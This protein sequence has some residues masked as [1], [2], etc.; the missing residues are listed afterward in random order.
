MQHS[1]WSA[2]GHPVST[3]NIDTN[4]DIYRN[5]P[6]LTRFECQVTT[7][8][9]G[10]VNRNGVSTITNTYTVSY[11]VWGD[12]GPIV[13]TLSSDDHGSAD[14]LLYQKCISSHCRVLA[15]DLLGRGM[16]DSPSDYGRHHD[17]ELLQSQCE[18][19]YGGFNP[20]NDACDPSN[21]VYYLP[22]VLKHVIS[23]GDTVIVVC[24]GSIMSTALRLSIL[25]PDIVKGVV[26][27]QPEIY[28]K[29]ID[30]NSVMMNTTIPYHPI[31]NQ[32]GILYCRIT[33]PTLVVG[34]GCE[35]YRLL[36]ALHSSYCQIIKISDIVGN[37]LMERPT[38]CAEILLNWIIMTFG[39]SSLADVFQGYN[40][41][42][43]GD[44]VRVQND[45]RCLF[46]SIPPTGISPLTSPLCHELHGERKCT[47]TGFNLNVTPEHITRS[48]SVI[49]S[50]IQERSTSRPNTDIPVV[51]ISAVN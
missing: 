47:F 1:I 17:D 11:S 22:Q 12:A 49:S 6:Q 23:E 42:W 41:T 34:S 29:S 37:V 39:H 2:F 50:E 24:Q 15:I 26:I 16:S 4:Y 20:N 45:L 36:Y 48:Q 27:Y 25:C 33:C 10:Y 30:G 21:D 46:Y 44:E 9:Y 32:E 43:R 18:M 38:S 35:I 5:T 3:D 28:S 13:V 51:T 31:H 7:P 8:Y 40:V 14:V 19:I